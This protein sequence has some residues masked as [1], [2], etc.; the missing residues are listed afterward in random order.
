MKVMGMMKLKLDY[1][2]NDYVIVNY[3][4][5]LFYRENEVIVIS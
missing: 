3:L 5:Q 4:E 2:E 1:L